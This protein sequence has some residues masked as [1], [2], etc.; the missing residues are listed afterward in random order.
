MASPRS[1]D[2]VDGQLSRS[3]TPVHHVRRG[4]RPPRA[5]GMV[6]VALPRACRWATATAIV[7]GSAR[8]IFDRSPLRGAFNAASCADSADRIDPVK[9]IGQSRAG[10][11]PTDARRSQPVG[12][13]PPPALFVPPGRHR[14][15]GRR[16]VSYVVPPAPPIPSNTPATMRSSA[17]SCSGSASSP[18][19]TVLARLKPSAT[20]S[21]ASAEPGSKI[22]RSG[23]GGAGGVRAMIDAAGSSGS[24]TG[25]AAAGSTALGSAGT[26]SAAA[27]SAALGSA[28][29]LADRS[30][31]VGRNRLSRSGFRRDLPVHGHPCCCAVGRLA[32]AGAES[33]G[34][35]ELP[36]ES[37]I[38]V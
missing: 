30:R 38:V 18:R 36:M 11:R 12:G 10:Q 27:G 5:R 28:D 3:P 6:H 20:E 4:N 7:V 15:A 24:A 23:I 19:P 14:C 32:H 34:H 26:G 13:P 35:T 29:R 25:S 1:A 31:S 16:P 22:A 8:I 2:V 37:M 21:S 33:G 17:D 9:S